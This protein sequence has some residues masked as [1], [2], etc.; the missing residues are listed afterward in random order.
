M[1]VDDFLGQIVP[2]APALAMALVEHLRLLDQRLLADRRLIECQQFLQFRLGEMVGIDA[3]GRIDELADARRIFFSSM[4]ATSLRSLAYMKL[5]CMN[6]SLGLLDH[7]AH[8]RVENVLDAFD[9]DDLLGQQRSRPGD[10][11]RR[12]GPGRRPAAR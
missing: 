7:A 3:R 1:L 12:T 8:Q 2:Q 4:A 5:V 10:G 11:L 6:M 9:V